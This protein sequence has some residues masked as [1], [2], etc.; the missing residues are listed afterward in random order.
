MA[1]TSLV[2][3]DTVF[4]SGLC[5]YVRTPWCRLLLKLLVVYSRELD[6]KKPMYQRTAAYGHFGRDSFPWEV[7]KKLKY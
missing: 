6:L 7:P 2:S 4:V 3:V 1:V 5:V